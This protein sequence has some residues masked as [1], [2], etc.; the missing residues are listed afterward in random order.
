MVCGC[1]IFLNSRRKAMARGGLSFR[2]KKRLSLEV[3]QII[4]NYIIG[5]VVSFGLGVSLILAFGYTIT[6]V[7]ASMEAELAHNQKVL[8]NRTSYFLFAPKTGDVIVFKQG[9]NDHLY[10]KRV[11]GTPGDTV[12]I[13]GGQLYVNDVMVKDD[14][15]KIADP[16]IA[17]DKIILGENEFFVMGDNRNNSEDSRSDTVG[18][19][20]RDQIIG[21]A[22]FALPSENGSMKPIR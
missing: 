8:V 21:K 1:P 17:E 4:R 15:D 18:P 19:I 14:F 16:G 2:R 20:D 6:N 10:I 22:W 11:V 9:N 7:G 3:K 12:Q 13:S 5:C